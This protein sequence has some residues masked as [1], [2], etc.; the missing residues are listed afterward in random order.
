ME[1]FICF[2]V[3]RDEKERFIKMCS[4][5]GIKSEE[6]FRRALIESEITIMIRD[7]PDPDMPKEQKPKSD[8]TKS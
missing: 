7:Y 5:L 1:E 6:W 2:P 3:T 4:S 8:E